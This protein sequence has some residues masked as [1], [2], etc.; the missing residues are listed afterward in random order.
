MFNKI[1]KNKE[2]KELL[3]EEILTK[4]LDNI[5]IN[6]YEYQKYNISMTDMKSL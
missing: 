6:C 4:K 3:I 2:E 1:I 5:I